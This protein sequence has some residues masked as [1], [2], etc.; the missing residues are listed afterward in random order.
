MVRAGAAVIGL[1]LSGYLAVEHYTAATTL[2]RPETGGGQ[3]SQGHRE[4]PIG[5]CRCTCRP[6]RP[7]VLRRPPG[8]APAR[9]MALAL[10]VAG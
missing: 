8:A 4:R 5:G 9:R 6:A 7:R 2:A 1:A 10:G 3:L